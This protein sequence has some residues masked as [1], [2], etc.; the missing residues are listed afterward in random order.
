MEHFPKSAP[1]SLGTTESYTGERHG[2]LM[3]L[4]EVFM[5]VRLCSLQ[6][7][8]ALYPP[9]YGSHNPVSPPKRSSHT[10]R[11]G[12]PSVTLFLALLDLTLKFGSVGLVRV[13]LY[14]PTSVARC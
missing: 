11:P 1:F 3:A 9:P 4:F 13:A 7:L 10:E 8:A 2:D 5:V 6:G 12:L 14:I